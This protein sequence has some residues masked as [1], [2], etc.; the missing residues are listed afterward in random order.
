[1]KMFENYTSTD[2]PTYLPFACYAHNT[3][4]HSTIQC[5]P[6]LLFHGHDPMTPLD[7]RF[8]P[9]RDR[10]P[11][12]QFQYSTEV[13]E[14]MATINEKAKECSVETYIKYRTYYDKQAKAQPLRLHQY[15][16]LLNP[17]LQEQNPILGWKQTR[18]IALYRVEKVLTD[19]NYLVR[20]VGTWFTQIT[21]RIRLRPFN[22]KY[23]PEVDDLEA[24]NENKFI[25]DP[26]VTPEESEPQIFDEKVK[27]LI[28]DGQP[29]LTE[30]QF[31]Q[32]AFRYTPI[33]SE[34]VRMRLVNNNDL[35]EKDDEE[36]V[37]APNAEAPETPLAQ[38]T[39]S[40]A[41][42]TTGP[43]P[44]KPQRERRAS[45]T[46]IPA[47]KTIRQKSP[48]ARPVTEVQ[49]EPV[50]V[51]NPEENPR[52]SQFQTCPEMPVIQQPNLPTI[53]ENNCM[54]RRRQR[55]PM[56]IPSEP[57]QR[58]PDQMFP[59]HNNDRRRTTPRHRPRVKTRLRQPPANT[60][61]NAATRSRTKC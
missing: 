25:P 37:V 41:T 27:A 43:A 32:S 54:V 10:I 5:T 60:M 11:T 55:E 6:S 34:S 29:P 13:K 7:L 24:I 52:R 40:A 42:I 22:P 20:K 15:C 51:I 45:R 21:H 50:D 49:Q 59:D 14:R 56:I 28:N 61:H 30:A 4:Y 16:L 3:S 53:P 9:S 58:T 48:C 26:Y 18:W 8:G 47:E 31:N 46:V 23:I 57:T 39:Q 38:W 44:P 1:M 17:K 2:W 12:T 35:P 19:M 36:Q 33:I